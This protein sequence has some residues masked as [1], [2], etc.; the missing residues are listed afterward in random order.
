MSD[1]AIIREALEDWAIWRGEGRQWEQDGKW[2][3]EVYDDE[4]SEAVNAL[5]A[6]DR[7]VARATI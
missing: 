3:R 5:A 1:E 4:D 6:L 7:L 2:H